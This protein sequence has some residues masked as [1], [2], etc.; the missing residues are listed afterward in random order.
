LEVEGWAD[1][2]SVEA[3]PEIESGRGRVI[4]ATF[5]QMS[6]G[7]L[8]LSVQAASGQTETLEPTS[9]HRFFS[10]DRQDWVAAKELRI[11]EK[12]R[13]RAGEIVAVESSSK[14]SG[15]YRVYNMEVEG[16]HQYFVGVSSTLV[17]NAYAAGG[18]YGKVKANGGEVHHAPANSI[19]PLSRNAGPA[20]RMR[21]KDHQQTASWGSSADAV[22]Y[23]AIQEQLI[24]KGKF[25]EAME[26]D[27]ID[28]RNLFGTRYD[29]RIARAVK[30]AVENIDDYGRLKKS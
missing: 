17:H 18:A 29:K 24:A 12:L 10:E 19:S 9:P 2:M 3:C 11:G 6:A 15:V 27:I 25:F 23:R 26:M 28:T 30:Y 22:A 21:V 20:W 5:T 8:E 7:V 4:T 13:T 1:V 16:E 14:K